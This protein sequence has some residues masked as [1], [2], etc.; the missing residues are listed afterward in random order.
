MWKPIRFEGLICYMSEFFNIGYHSVPALQLAQYV[1]WRADKIGNRITHLQLQKILYYI[2]GYHLSV[3]GVPLFDDI[4]S[5]WPY[6]P[7]VDVVYKK[8]FIFGAIKL[9]QEYEPILPI[10]DE[11]KKLINAIID[12]KSSLTGIM[13]VSASCSEKPWKNLEQQAKEHR[14]PEITIESIR[15]FFSRRRYGSI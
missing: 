4:I 13:L 3:F 5:A 1:V 9:T 8:Y 7:V 10:R 14:R 6:G 11:Q 2:Q 15:E 12:D